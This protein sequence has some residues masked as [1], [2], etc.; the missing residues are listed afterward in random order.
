MP[1]QKEKE[2]FIQLVKAGDLQEISEELQKKPYLIKS[3]DKPGDPG[4][5]KKTTT[6][7]CLCIIIFVLL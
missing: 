4:F 1:S 6:Q 5:G 7:V 3:R 2:R